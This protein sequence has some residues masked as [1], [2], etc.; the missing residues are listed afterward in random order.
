MNVGATANA[1]TTA[2]AASAANVILCA[3]IAGCYDI[4]YKKVLKEHLK[5]I[6]AVMVESEEVAQSGHNS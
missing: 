4:R 6:C 1:I 5:D 3:F 2:V